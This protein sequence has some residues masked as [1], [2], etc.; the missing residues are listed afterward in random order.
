MS[1]P[2]KRD[3]LIFIASVYDPLGLINLFVT[4]LK[5]LFHKLIISKLGWDSY[6]D[7]EILLEWQNIIISPFPTLIS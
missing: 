6:L 7:A 4:K 3:V 1:I 2:R 5:L